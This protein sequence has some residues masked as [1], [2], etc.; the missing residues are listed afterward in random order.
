MTSTEDSIALPPLGERGRIYG[1]AYLAHV[2]L[3]AE[4]SDG[5]ATTEQAAELRRTELLMDLSARNGAAREDF[6]AVADFV[7]DDPHTT[8]RADLWSLRADPD[9]EVLYPDID[10][11][12]A[13]YPL[14]PT[15]D[16]ET[17]DMAAFLLRMSSGEHVFAAT[18]ITFI[19]E[20]GEAGTLSSAAATNERNDDPEHI[21]RPIE[22]NGMPVAESSVDTGQERREN[23]RQPLSVTVYKGDSM[24]V[25]DGNE[26]IALSRTLGNTKRDVTEEA[27]VERARLSALEILAANPD[28]VFYTA[29]LYER[30]F[31]GQ[32][33]GG[34]TSSTWEH[35]VGKFLEDTLLYGG[36]PIVR[37]ERPVPRR[38]TYQLGDFAP[39]FSY[40]D[41][42][43]GAEQDAAFK[44][45]DG[46]LLGGMAGRLMHR[47]VKATAESPFGMKELHEMLS[48]MDDMSAEER[49]RMVDSRSTLSGLVSSVRSALRQREVDPAYKIHAV[50]DLRGSAGEAKKPKQ[51]WIESLSYDAEKQAELNE[52]FRAVGFI[53]DRPELFRALELPLL[54]KNVATVLTKA[55][56]YHL[57]KK[58]VP[59]T[60]TAEI[61]LK[62]LALCGED[63][64]IEAQ[65][66]RPET[67]PLLPLVNYLFEQAG[68]DDSLFEAALTAQLTKQRNTAEG[69]E[70]TYDVPGRGEVTVL[71]GGQT[72][73]DGDGADVDKST[74]AKPP[75]KEK[76]AEDQKDKGTEGA[77]SEA[78]KELKAIVGEAA[79]DMVYK[80][81]AKV[82]EQLADADMSGQAKFNIFE[83]RRIFRGL[84]MDNIRE[85]THLAYGR[86]DVHDLMP[87]DIATIY[88]M[89][90]K[91]TRR[92]I[93]RHHDIVTRYA[94]SRLSGLLAANEGVA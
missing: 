8:T 56:P 81:V 60:E 54:D 55:V 59:S 49:A 27:E 35:Y 13:K 67:D 6:A 22:G 62:L 64:Y 21:E 18:D 29:E 76:A 83:V 40:E 26:Q 42:V 92:A 79:M 74:A 5:E 43:S 3:T 89:K 48:T 9:L 25:L 11:E 36:R 39:I 84:T 7:P 46:S 87:S 30:V 34:K 4:I 65:M 51:Y 24:L 82:E 14:P 90:H 41:G 15:Y 52:A 1:D 77:E 86:S 28:H 63:A 88:S 70:L 69:T 61:A 20:P 10:A 32:K 17:R 91:A 85:Y 47:L 45:P 37:V 16:R 66:D 75:K 72:P 33:F 19:A 44:L 31:P 38:K 80:C 23:G 53:T 58:F 50:D 73:P 78:D 93:S 12:L 71:R 94:A 68:K 57:A 2:S